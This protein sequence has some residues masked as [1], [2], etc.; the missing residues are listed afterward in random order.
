M[1]RTQ[2]KRRRQQGRK[3]AVIL[4]LAVTALAT[5]AAWKVPGQSWESHA[6]RQ[7]EKTVR[8]PEVKDEPQITMATL[9]PT[10]KPEETE[11]PEQ[12]RTYMG[13]FTVTAYCSCEI[14]CGKWANDRPNGIVYTASGAVAEEGVTVGAAWDILPKGAHIEI[15]GLG[16]RIVQDR[17]ADWIIERYEGK[18]IDAYFASHE[19]AQEYG[20]HTVGVWIIEDEGKEE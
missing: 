19:A 12:K 9:T 7:I 13:E 1:N 6:E 5:A 16:E 15:E 11:Q 2:R 3:E 18:I 14:C 4:I 17:P 20:K 8:T 10:E